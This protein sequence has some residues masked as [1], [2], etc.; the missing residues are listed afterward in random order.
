[1]NALISLDSILEP[2]PGTLTAANLFGTGAVE[3]LLNAIETNVRAEV[4][5]LDTDEGRERIKSVA[6]KIARSKTTLDEIGKE[7][8]A[9]IKKQAGAIDAERRTIRDRLDALKDSVRKPLTDWEEAEEKRIG[10]AEG[11]LVAV[12][13]AGRQAAGKSPSLIRELIEIVS[14]Y[15]AR[16]WQEFKE[17]AD[18]AV[19]EALATLNQALAD[20][21]QA[22]RDAAELAAL[23]AEKAARDER[24]RQEAAAKAKADAEAKEAAAAAEREKARAA[25]AEREKAEQEARAKRQ[26]EEAAA[27]AVEQ[28]RQRVAAEAQRQAAEKAAQEEAE[29]RRQ[30]DVDHRKAVLREIIDAMVAA[31]AS[32]TL[33]TVLAVEIDSGTIPHVSITY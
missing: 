11:A 26:A 27:R 17:R 13:E 23:R 29:R 8:V 12:V 31:G 9:E 7:H 20:A 18:V 6:Y 4:F 30:L 25:Q 24:D 15:A 19:T 2:A 22:E 3:A 14:G 16:D 21:E 10:E 1:M 28:E 5:T 32:A 33:A